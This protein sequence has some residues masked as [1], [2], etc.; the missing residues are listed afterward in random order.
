MSL[1]EK[2]RYTGLGLRLM[3]QESDVLIALLLDLTERGIGFVPCHDGL[4]VPEFKKKLTHDLMLKHY[5]AITGQ[6]IS[7][8]EKT[9]SKPPTAPLI[10]QRVNLPARALNAVL[11]CRLTPYRHLPRASDPHRSWLSCFYN[12]INRES[13][14]HHHSSLGPRSLC[15][16][17]R[18]TSALREQ[19]TAS[20]LCPLSFKPRA[21]LMTLP[22]L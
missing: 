13:N 3:R 15:C 17:Y 20:N 6:R 4:M 1:V 16:V 10:M 12:P 19:N 2:Y 18:S 9:I 7:V 5:Q 22:S 21:Y 11:T 8:K 14:E